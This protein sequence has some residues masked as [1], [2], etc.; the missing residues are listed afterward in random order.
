MDGQLCT[1]GWPLLRHMSGWPMR[2]ASMGRVANCPLGQKAGSPDIKLTLGV[3]AVHCV[4]SDGEL[5]DGG[6]AQDDVEGLVLENGRKH[7][8]H[9]VSASAQK[10]V[11]WTSAVS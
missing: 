4:G 6:V 5:G 8:A 3:S 11:S 10:M 9:T 2:D 7:T 1:Y